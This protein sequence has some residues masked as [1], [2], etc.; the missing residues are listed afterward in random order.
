MIPTLVPGTADG[1]ALQDRIPWVGGRFLPLKEGGIDA[2][3]AKN[4][5]LSLPPS[6]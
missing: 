4:P 6:N 1:W 3:Q 5:E 2:G